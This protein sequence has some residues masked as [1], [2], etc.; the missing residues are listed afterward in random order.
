MLYDQ[1]VFKR[2]GLKDY[3]HKATRKLCFSER[4]NVSVELELY[5]LI[6]I[7]NKYSQKT[8]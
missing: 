5:Y 7:R 1:L 6:S 4:Q 3:T 2:I 8:F